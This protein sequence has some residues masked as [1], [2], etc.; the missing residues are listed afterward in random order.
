MSEAG[1]VAADLQSRTLARVTWRLVAFSFL[2]Y[3]VAY[4]D[5]I[6]SVS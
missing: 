4:I 6:T 2:C 1:A 5:R 3:V